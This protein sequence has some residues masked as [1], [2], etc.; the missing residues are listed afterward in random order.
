MGQQIC[1]THLRASKVL[2]NRHLKQVLRFDAGGAGMIM[3][4]RVTGPPVPI[5][6]RRRGYILTMDQSDAGGTGIFP[7]R[8][9]SW[10]GPLC[11]RI[12]WTEVEWGQSGGLAVLNGGAPALVVF[13]VLAILIAALFWLLPSLH[14]LRDGIA[15]SASRL[16]MPSS[17]SLSS[18]HEFESAVGDSYSTIMGTSSIE[19][20]DTSRLKLKIQAIRRL[21]S[22]NN[23]G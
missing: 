16:S 10:D 13:G 23:L 8:P 18:L 20:M 5:A 9:L 19:S 4:L 6:A 11:G 7:R 1:C 12:N 21:G 14:L 2:S 3:L 15:R 22:F 17:N